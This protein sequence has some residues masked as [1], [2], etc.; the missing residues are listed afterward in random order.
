[1]SSMDQVTMAQPSDG[2]VASVAHPGRQAGGMP[3]TG[4]AG[5]LGRLA[6]RAVAITHWRRALITLCLAFA[7]VGLAGLPDGDWD[8]AELL[9]PFLPYM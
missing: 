3:T 5:R 4:H 6:A 8:D 2:V 1:M 7:G 9:L